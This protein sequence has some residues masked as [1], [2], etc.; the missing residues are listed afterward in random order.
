MLRCV[1]KC[2]DQMPRRFIVEDIDLSN[3]YTMRRRWADNQKAILKDLV[4]QAK[5][6]LPL[7]GGRR[8]V[9]EKDDQCAGLA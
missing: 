8:N 2:N 1:R 7:Q 6:L 4:N 5:S 9:S 3:C